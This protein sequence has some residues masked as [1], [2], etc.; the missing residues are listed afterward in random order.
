[1]NI[2]EFLSNAKKGSIDVK[3]HSAKVLQELK[4]INKEYFYLNAMAESPG[5]GRG[6]ISG[7][8]ISVKDCLC[9]KGMES[10]AGSAILKGY[11]P[12][13]DAT[14]VERCRK[15]GA[16]IL[17][18]TAQDEFGFGSFN[19]NV[20]NGFKIPLNPIDKNR[21]CG[22]SSGGAA[23]LAK[24]ASFPH[25]ALAESTGGSIVAPA[26]FC[27]VVGMCPTYGRV[28]RYGLIDY[29]N[30]LDKIGPIAQSVEDT[31]FIL[32]LIAGHD[33]KDSTS[34]TEKVDSYISALSKG[35]K[36]KT[37][38]ILEEGFGEGVDPA[39]AKR[40][41]DAIS[42]LESLGAKT[43]R[44]SLPLNSKYSLESYYVLATAEASTN[45]AKYCGMR[46]GAHENLHGSFNE[47]FTEVRSK[48]LGPEAKRRIL[49][50][51]FA[52]MA[53]YSA[54]FYSKAGKV[55][56]L[57]I[58]EYKKA[59]KKVDLIASPTMPII[60]P[61]F[62]EVKKLTPLQQ[63]KMDLLTVGPNLAGLPHISV[64]CGDVKGMPV[65]L[66]LIADHF[67]ESLLFSAGGSYENS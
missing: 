43:A 27:G 4:K 52:R 20:G 48:N 25:V 1:M 16:F 29:A 67:N 6:K 24:K 12:L 41:K 40:V 26:A 61:T 50:G 14:A 34:S 54:K 63:Y 17:G 46:Y 5:F 9:V 58:D 28:S 66:Q 8:P 18:K 21:V 31:A 19:A 36:G 49:L 59:F 53:G 38:G 47:Y 45:L 32:E 60:A 39:L 33:I 65:G 13:F 42:K 55:R 56:T 44:I 23:G 7:L 51:T 11:V 30:S 2:R 10:T 57:I 62:D 22:G 15:D 37:I 35:I 3:E 64:P